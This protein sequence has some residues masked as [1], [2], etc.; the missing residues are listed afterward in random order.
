MI[1]WTDNIGL[2]LAGRTKY[3]GLRY[4]IELE[5]EEFHDDYPDLDYWVC[6]R[7]PSLRRGG[8]EY[9]SNPLGQAQIV[10][11]LDEVAESIDEHALVASWRCGVH[12]HLNVSD[13]T[14]KE[15]IQFTVLYALCEP[16]IF[17]NFAP[18]RET[19][20]FCVPVTQNT[21]LID[22]IANDAVELRAGTAV[23][24]QLGLLACSKYSALNFKPMSNLHT[25]EFRHLEGTVDMGQVQQ[26]CGL[27]EKLRE[28]SLLF[29]GPE[30][31]VMEFEDLGVNALLE[32]LGLHTCEVSAEDAEDAYIA[33]CAM[34]GHDPV[35]WQE[36]EW[37]F[38]PEED[39]VLEPLVALR[40]EELYDEEEYEEEDY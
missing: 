22:G 24:E 40:H 32:R 35:R 33:A 13:W 38:A 8:I 3:K 29:E 18:G 21:K 36:L 1:Q 39:Q 2:S 26:W 7:D 20:H 11:A 30:D 31:I 34:C 19:S 15:L 23:R 17:G 27:L 5:F 28:Q 16:F 9:I 25:I 37:E 10:P 6:E 4:G 12:V 14:F